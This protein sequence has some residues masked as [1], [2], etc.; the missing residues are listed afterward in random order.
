VTTP[1][2][3]PRLIG[4]CGI[5][6][7]IGAHACTALADATVILVLHGTKLLGA[8]LL[9]LSLIC[10]AD[11]ASLVFECMRALIAILGQ[12]R[13]CRARKQEIA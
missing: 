1:P 7:I 8:G 10:H 9:A 11:R 3:W 13:V 6:C 4:L 2:D 12:L 5:A